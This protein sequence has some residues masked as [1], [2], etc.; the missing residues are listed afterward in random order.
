MARTFAAWIIRVTFA[1]QSISY[2]GPFINKDRAE[3]YAT[4]AEIVDFVIEPL[5]VPHGIFLDI[6]ER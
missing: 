2:H 3:R 5:V 4:C 1:D 6:T